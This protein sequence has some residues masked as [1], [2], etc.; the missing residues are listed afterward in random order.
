MCP[1]GK[2]TYKRSELLSLNTTLA[3]CLNEDKKKYL[4]CSKRVFILKPDYYDSGKKKK[5]KRI[6]FLA[7]TKTSWYNYNVKEPVILFF[8]LAL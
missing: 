1:T 2:G 3:A 6:F 8:C 5:T 4:I 7:S